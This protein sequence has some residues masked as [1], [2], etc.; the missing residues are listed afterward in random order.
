[1]NDLEVPDT[2]QLEVLGFKFGDETYMYLYPTTP[3]GLEVVVGIE[4][5]RR[6]YNYCMATSLSLHW[7]YTLPTGKISQ[8]FCLRDDPTIGQIKE[9]I[10]A[11]KGE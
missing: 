10:R 8:I 1:M 2:D 5:N 7:S 4:T 3:D 9:L 11:L 6:A